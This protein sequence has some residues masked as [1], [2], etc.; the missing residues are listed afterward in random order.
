VT[1]TDTYLFVDDEPI[2]DLTATLFDT[3]VEDVRTRSETTPERVPE[4]VR[5]GEIDGIAFAVGSGESGRFVLA[6]RL[7]R[8]G[9]D[10][11]CVA[12]ADHLSPEVRREAARRN[13]TAC[14]QKR[15]TEETMHVVH[16]ALSTKDPDA[17][18]GETGNRIGSVFVP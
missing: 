11:P 2:A 16:D 13:V 9:I 3:V 18:V 17:L 15:L 1:V 7:D 4:R 5:N 8:S 10:V 12:L 6:D 14:V